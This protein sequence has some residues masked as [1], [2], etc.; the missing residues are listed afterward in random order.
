PDEGLEVEISD[1]RPLK[2]GAIT[3]LSLLVRVPPNAPIANRRGTE[4]A[5]AGSILIETTHPR[6]KRM[7]IWVRY[8]VE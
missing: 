1:P 4:Q 5:P 7:Q 2:N 8:A 3:Q 6:I